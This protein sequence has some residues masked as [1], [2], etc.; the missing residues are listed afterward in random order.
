MVV[1]EGVVRFAIKE[2]AGIG[3]RGASL[4]V[5][6]LFTI[7]ANGNV[8][9]GMLLVIGAGDSRFFTGSGPNYTS[10]AE[11]FG[12][13]VKNGDGTF[14]Y[15]TKTQV[16]YNF[17]SNGYLTSVVQPSGLQISYG[18]DAQNRLSTVTAPDGATTTL[19]PCSSDSG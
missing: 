17:N 2:I 18:Y 8:P 4:G 3:G 11:D 7:S 5:A 1:D 12:T 10:P 9:A 19:T 16:K 6:R 15:T 14:S 13:L